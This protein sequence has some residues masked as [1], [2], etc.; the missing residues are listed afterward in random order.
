MNTTGRKPCVVAPIPS[1]QLRPLALSI[2]LM[3]PYPSHP[4]H[5]LFVSTPPLHSTSPLLL[6]TPP[7]H[8]SSPLH[9]H[10]SSH[11]LLPPLRLPLLSLEPLTPTPPLASPPQVATFGISPPKVKARLEY[12]Q[13][14]EEDAISPVGRSPVGQRSGFQQGKLMASS[15]SGEGEGGPLGQFKNTP[16]LEA[17]RTGGVIISAVDYLD[18]LKG[19][20]PKLLAW[21][22]L[23]RDYPHYRKGHCLVQVCVGAR[24]RIKLQEAPAVEAE[25]RRIVERINGSFPG[26]GA[27]RLPSPPLVSSGLL[28]SPLASSHLLSPPL[29]SSH[30]PFLHSARSSPTTQSPSSRSR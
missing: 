5:T 26:A 25:L 19:V 4:R 27:C 12:L 29:T 10:S 17:C 11:L 24:N 1:C 21:E 22:A 8:S 3:S 9:L 16:L 20:A 28:S 15:A 13:Q 14:M 7:L 30:P 6:S 18:R 2:T 23:L